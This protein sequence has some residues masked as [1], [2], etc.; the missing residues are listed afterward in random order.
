MTRMPKPIWNLKPRLNRRD[1]FV[2]GEAQESEILISVADGASPQKKV[3]H[4][5]G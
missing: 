2:T 4:L 1:L 5:Y 3:S